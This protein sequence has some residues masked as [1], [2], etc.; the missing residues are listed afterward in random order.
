MKILGL[1]TS[2][3][4]NFS[5]GFL[6]N[7]KIIELNFT[8]FDNT[9]EYITH[10]INSIVEIYNISLKEIDLFA[11]GI[12]PG[13]FTG[14]R[15]GLSVIKTFAWAAKKNIIPIS[16][17]ELLANSFEI[18]NNEIVIP[19]LD[20]RREKIFTSIFKNNRRL[21][22]DMDITIDELISFLKVENEE[23]YFIGEGIKK[24]K[25]KLE[26]IPYKKHFYP[27]INIKGATIIKKA[28]ETIEKHPE[29]LIDATTLEP[30]YL[31]K[32]EAELNLIK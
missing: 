16:S 3:I 24:Y 26:V 12:G 31:R 10:S 2:S 30:K 20:A 15:I 21:T 27:D 32:S 19:I 9:D 7:D 5:M 25:E 4:N 13:S 14:L 8:N 6:D 23:I 11:V 28:K 1:D 29:K 17:L 22:E 18:K